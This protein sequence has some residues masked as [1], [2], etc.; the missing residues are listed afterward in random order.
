M[1]Q[2]TISKA[3]CNG[4]QRVASRAMFPFAFDPVISNVLSKP[5]QRVGKNLSVDEAVS[6]NGLRMNIS[7]V[8]PLLHVNC[9]IIPGDGDHRAEL[10]TTDAPELILRANVGVL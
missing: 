4:H 3:R 9:A 5:H 10:L 7:G 6:E 1:P 2:F 8:L